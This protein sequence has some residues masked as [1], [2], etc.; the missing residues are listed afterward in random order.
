MV[1]QHKRER[2]QVCVNALRRDLLE[3]GI[4][5]SDDA[6]FGAWERHSE[7][8]SAGWLAL[9]SDAEANVRALVKNFDID[10]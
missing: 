8:Q 7:S 10:R 9:Y 2:T 6:I 5:A 4:E 3:F 1:A